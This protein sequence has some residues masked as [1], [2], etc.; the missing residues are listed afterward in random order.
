M[1]ILRLSFLAVLAL[2]ACGVDG[3]P[4][5]PKPGVAVS[6]EVQIGVVSN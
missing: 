6:G 1:M 3:E 2:S 5:P 4:T